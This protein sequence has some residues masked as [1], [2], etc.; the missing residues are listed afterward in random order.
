MSPLPHIS[1][2]PMMI[3]EFTLLLLCSVRHDSFFFPVLSYICPIAAQLVLTKADTSWLT[4]LTSSG[5]NL[6]SHHLLSHYDLPSVYKRPACQAQRVGHLFFPF[7]GVR[8]F[9]S[10][11]AKRRVVS[12]F[13]VTHMEVQR[14]TPLVPQVLYC[15]PR[16]KTFLLPTTHV[17]QIWPKIVQVILGVKLLHCSPYSYVIFSLMLSFLGKKLSWTFKTSSWLHTWDTPI[18]CC[19]WVQGKSH[20]CQMTCKLIYKKRFRAQDY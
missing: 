3:K 7:H 16:V 13:L 12:D 15:L 18:V 10:L 6:A 19:V 8:H 2:V 5:N 1:Y 20:V 4:L 17:M 14:S 9:Y 11:Y